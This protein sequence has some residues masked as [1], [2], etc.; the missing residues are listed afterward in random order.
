M[1]RVAP[2]WR[3]PLALVIGGTLAAVLC[4]PLIAIGYLKVAGDILG[5]A[6]TAWLLGWMAVIATSILGFLLWRLVLRPVYALTVH[7]RSVR[8]GQTG[9]RPPD[10]FGTPEF[11][12]LADSVIDMGAALQNRTASL[13]AYADHVTHELK[14]PLTAITGAA[15]LLET[16]LSP[17]DRAALGATITQAASRMQ[18]LLDDMR[19]HAVASQTGEL[20]ETDLL[21]G[22]ERIDIEGLEMIVQVGG[23]IPLPPA[24]LTV[25]LTQ[26]AQNAADHGAQ[27][28]TLNWAGSELVVSDDG[29]GVAQGNRAR[30]FD[31][32]FTTR[33][34][35]GGTGMGL[36]IVHSLLLARGAQI[37]LSPTEIGTEFVI[38]F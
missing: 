27:T 32:F 7:A 11:S 15:E 37:V 35:E 23:M 28:L 31:P 38:A 2:K 21:E 17:E 30:I 20:G 8:V 9:V 16:D 10:H 12:D 3:P 26:L 22:A 19:Q 13:R 1:R 6:E 25:V 24:D 33:R 34:D 5:R 29:S 36:S 18:R 14:S 4:L